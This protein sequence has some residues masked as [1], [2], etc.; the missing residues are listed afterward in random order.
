M[1]YGH[2]GGL[3]LLART[4]LS[5]A[6]L[7]E[8][9]GID[10]FVE[11]R[12]AKWDGDLGKKIHSKDASLRPSRMLPWRGISIPSRS[13]GARSTSRTWSTGSSEPGQTHDTVATRT[14]H[15]VAA[16]GRGFMGCDS[17]G[18]VD[19]H[20]GIHARWRL[21]DDELGSALDG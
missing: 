11:Q 7:I 1:F 4:L 20:E 5:A 10:K 6:A 17:Q 12:Y 2:V 19:R 16:R 13:R 8:N 3:D 21:R 18:G 15:C 14:R 9:G